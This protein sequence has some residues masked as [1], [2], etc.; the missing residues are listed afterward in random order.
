MHGLWFPPGFDEDRHRVGGGLHIDAILTLLAD[1]QHSVV[2]AGQVLGLGL[3][4]SHVRNRVRSGHLHVIGRGAYLVGRATPTGVSLRMASV[5][6]AGPDAHLDDLTAAAQLGARVR[7]PAKVHIVVPPGRRVRRPGVASRDVVILPHERTLAN[8]IPCLTMA[9]VLLGVS[10]HRNRRTTEDLWHEAVFRKLVDDDALRRVL[11]DH[12][13]EPGIVLL[14]ELFERRVRAIGDVANRLEAE[15]RELVV[16]AGMPEPRSNMAITIAG[17]R[18]VPDLYVPQ[19]RL[20]FESDGRDGHGPPEQQMS[21]LRR[22]ELY[23]SVGL[24]VYRT[25]WWAVH[26]EGHRV[27]DDLVRFERAWQLTGGIWTPEA[28]EPVVGGAATLRRAA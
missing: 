12:A 3:S 19:R 26:Y 16:A 14:R 28:P 20:V 4:R 11:A 18:L 9:R 27:L 1:R 25:G 17:H 21:D 10:A 23:R 8:G 15:L 13:G 6:V 24:T 7:V 2:S 22:D 5:L